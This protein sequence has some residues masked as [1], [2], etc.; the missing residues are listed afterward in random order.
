MRNANGCGIY[1]VKMMYK[2]FIELQMQ[3][4][5]TWKKNDVRCLVSLTSLIH[6]HISKKAEHYKLKIY[7]ISLFTA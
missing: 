4:T 1:F 5:Q 2:G 3:E 6:F 7:N